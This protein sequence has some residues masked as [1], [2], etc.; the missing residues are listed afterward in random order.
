MA[1][2]SFSFSPFGLLYNRILQAER[3]INNRYVFLTVL[4]P[5]KS[6]IKM[7]A[8]LASG[9]ELLTDGCH[10]AVSSQEGRGK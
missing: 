6:K 9:Q 4:G 8:D 1:D 5:G 2:N 10:F 3:I 7:L